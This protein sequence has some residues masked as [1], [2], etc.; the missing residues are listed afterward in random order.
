[1]NVFTIW[2]L[3]DQP[4][5]F[6]VHGMYWADKVSCALAHKVFVECPSIAELAVAK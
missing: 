6:R 5:S 4:L 1:M 3:A 2:G